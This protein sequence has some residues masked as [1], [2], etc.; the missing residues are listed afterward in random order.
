M[1]NFEKQ[2]LV[3]QINLL[4]SEMADLKGAFYKNNFSNSQTFV[5]SVEF[6][7]KL[8]VPVYTT[9][10]T[11]QV[12][13]ILVASGKLYVCSATNTWTIVGTQS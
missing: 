6:S 8:K 5:K 9:L 13:E 2:E 1:D 3:D 12:G 11:C 10:P 4:K 7:T